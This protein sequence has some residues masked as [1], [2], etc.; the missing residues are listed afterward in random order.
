MHGGM[1]TMTEVADLDAAENADVRPRP[2]T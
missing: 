1:F 2:V